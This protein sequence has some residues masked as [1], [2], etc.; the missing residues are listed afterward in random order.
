[1]A[2]HG[3]WRQKMPL[4]TLYDYPI[5]KYKTSSWAVSWFGEWNNVDKHKEAFSKLKQLHAAF[6]SL[7]SN[8]VE[9]K[10]LKQVFSTSCKQKVAL[11]QLPISLSVLRQSGAYQKGKLYILWE[12]LLQAW[13]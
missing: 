8:G 5:R 13:S 1:M 10:T 12:S 9:R 11:S 7:L 2:V 4:K 3:Y 6:L